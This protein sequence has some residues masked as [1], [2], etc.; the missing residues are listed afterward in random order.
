M[1]AYLFDSFL[2]ERKYQ[3]DI[4][5][6]ENRLSTLGIQGKIEKM[7]ILK[8][9]Q[10]AARQAIKRGVATLVVVG[11]DE[12]ITKVLPQII[13]SDVTLGLIPLGP[14]Q[15]IAR[16]LGIPDGVVACDV[17]SRRILRRLDLGRANA[18]YFLFN[19]VAPA[20]VTVDCGGQYRVTSLDPAGSLMTANF[21]PAGTAG[22]PDDGRLELIVTPGRGARGWLPGRRSS[23]GSV[24]SITKAKFTS[25]AGPV[26]LTLDG[27]VTVK[28]P[29]TVEVVRRKLEVI[30]GKDRA[31]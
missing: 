26:N 31:F 3:H 30:V 29:A 12:T 21:P 10:E 18:V 23:G 5:Q 25:P 20:D 16:A 2:Q 6:I 13:D 14:Q 28:T 17:L 22:Q 7:T 15:T 8:N 24:F 9:I 4:G 19:L 11:N 27:Q 1:Y